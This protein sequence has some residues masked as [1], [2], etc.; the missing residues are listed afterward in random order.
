M[1]LSPLSRMKRHGPRVNFNSL[2]KK[3]LA[4]VFKE[5]VTDMKTQFQA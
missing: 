4:L 3:S 5:P 2:L 1:N